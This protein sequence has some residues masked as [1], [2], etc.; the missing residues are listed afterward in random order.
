MQCFNPSSLYFIL[1]CDW[2]FNSI[3]LYCQQVQSVVE[4]TQNLQDTE[5][6]VFSS[7]LT[8]WLHLY[9]FFLSLFRTF[10][11]R[12]ANKRPTKIPFSSALYWPMIIN[13]ILIRALWDDLHKQAVRNIAISQIQHLFHLRNSR[14]LYSFKQGERTSITNLTLNALFVKPCYMFRPIQPSHG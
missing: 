1:D 12:I 7:L 11:W 10:K 3:Q 14:H 9:I 6:C 8:F 5:Q 2:I 13:P 4:Y